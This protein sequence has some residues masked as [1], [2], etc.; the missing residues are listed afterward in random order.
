M[1]DQISGE[2]KVS[3]DF[4]LV[5]VNKLNEVIFEVNSF[6]AKLQSASP[7]NKAMN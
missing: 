1:I 5:V 3:S 7:I 4:D 2:Q 6:E